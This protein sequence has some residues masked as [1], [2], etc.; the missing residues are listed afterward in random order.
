MIYRNPFVNVFKLSMNLMTGPV[1]T[2]KYQTHRQIRRSWA[3][4]LTAMAQRT[5]E[6][7]T[8]K[9]TL[10]YEYIFSEL[11]TSFFPLG[12]FGRPKNEPIIKIWYLILLYGW[13]NAGNSPISIHTE[14]HAPSSGRARNNLTTWYILIISSSNKRVFFSSFVGT[15][16]WGIVAVRS[17]NHRGQREWNCFVFV[18][19]CAEWVSQSDGL[20]WRMKWN[21]V[22]LLLLFFSTS[23][24]LDD[25][26][27]FFSSARER[28]QHW[29]CAADGC[30]GWWNFFCAWT[31]NKHQAIFNWTVFGWLYIYDMAHM[32]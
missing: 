13:A 6:Y 5:V 10:K 32:L 4:H 15:L 27:V 30:V 2:R 22:D 12:H 21:I 18:C 28:I 25:V 7:I 17:S 3:P 14:I 16:F 8:P 11:E 29:P 23:L 9:G 19:L 1:Q 24:R 31:N 26:F 20:K